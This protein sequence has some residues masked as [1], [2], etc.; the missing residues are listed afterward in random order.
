MTFIPDKQDHQV[1]VPFFEE[2]S[3]SEGWV[4]YTTTK[5]VEQLQAEITLAMSRLGGMVT[6][7]QAGIFENENNPEKNRLGYVFY[8]NI[9]M[10]GENLHQGKIEVAA[11]PL[12]SSSFD[13]EQKTRKMA[14]YMFREYL[15]GQWFIQRLSPGLFPLLPFMLGDGKN[16]ISQMFSISQQLPALP[17]RIPEGGQES[18]EGTFK[19]IND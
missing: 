3:K 12:R 13:K 2:A 15:H 19:E 16:T 17:D 9:A 4:G 7:I 1:E 5:T 11:L 14:L 6:G 18:I 10:P 8:F